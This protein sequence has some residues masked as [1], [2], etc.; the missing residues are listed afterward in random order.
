MQTVSVKAK[1]FQGKAS[2]STLWLLENLEQRC[3]KKECKCIGG[4]T[5][6]RNLLCYRALKV[7]KVRSRKHKEMAV[8]G[9]II[10]KWS[11][12][13]FAWQLNR[14]TVFPNS[15][16]K[17][18]QSCRSESKN[19]LSS[20]HIHPDL[21]LYVDIKVASG[22]LCKATTCIQSTSNLKVNI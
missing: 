21:S 3:K 6:L 18:C 19:R 2:Q 15:F 14:F 7:S 22:N 1:P 5:L 12:S 8:Y 20:T 13:K 11:V 9:K 17:K 16:G 10:S 4:G